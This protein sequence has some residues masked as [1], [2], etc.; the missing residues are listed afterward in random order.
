MAALLEAVNIM[1][2]VCASCLGQAL[3]CAFSLSSCGPA[4]SHAEQLVHLL[5]LQMKLRA[6]QV[7]HWAQE[8]SNSASENEY[9]LDACRSN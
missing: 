5:L 9:P 4:A 3:E 7:V 2:A 8:R 6:L 1:P